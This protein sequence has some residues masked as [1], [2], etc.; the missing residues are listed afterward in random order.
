METNVKLMVTLQKLYITLA[1]S[2]GQNLKELGMTGSEFLVL[3]HLN[4]K[5]KEKVQKLAETA[6]I[7]SGTITYTINKLERTNM[8]TR[9]Q[10]IKDKRV[11]WVELTVQGRESY[12]QIF[13]KHM[14]YMDCLLGG[15]SEEEK[16]AFTER[17]KCFG[18]KID[19]KEKI[20]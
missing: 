13:K 6:M 4:R 17:I 16:I 7:T 8:I 14:E 3:S 1:K 10:D 18:I 15:F 19:K 20:K 2:S 11:F 12:K 9:E 5:G